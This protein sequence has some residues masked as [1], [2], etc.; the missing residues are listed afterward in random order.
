MFFFLVFFLLNKRGYTGNLLP[1][2]KPF[3]Q[4]NAFSKLLLICR[5]FCNIPCDCT[6]ID[7]LSQYATCELTLHWTTVNIYSTYSL[8]L[9]DCHVFYN[10]FSQDA[11]HRY[12]SLSSTDQW[13]KFLTIIQA[14]K[15]PGWLNRSLFSCL[16]KVVYISENG[17]IVS[18]RP[19]L[20][21][22]QSLPGTILCC[23]VAHHAGS[24]DILR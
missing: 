4:R 6:V 13:E 7:C 10:R 2:R 21:F 8:S 20:Y 23:L 11:T 17:P 18:V 9:L 14:L 15:F 1:E 12:A 24:S 16:W 19:R 3:E 5:L 22:W